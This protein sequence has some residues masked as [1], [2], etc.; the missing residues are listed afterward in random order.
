VPFAKY[1]HS[2]RSRDCISSAASIFG[3]LRLATEGT[4]KLS[5][6]SNVFARKRAKS[7]ALGKHLTAGLGSQ[8][9]KLNEQRKIRKA[10][11][12]AVHPA[13]VE[14]ED[15]PLIP[16]ERS[17]ALKCYTSAGLSGAAAFTYT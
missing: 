6:S 17:Y 15:V 14:A 1:D 7:L 12:G 3:S 9:N 13:R 4:V 2:D 16:E 10:A 5:C 11:H 8:F